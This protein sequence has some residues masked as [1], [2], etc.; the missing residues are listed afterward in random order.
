MGRVRERG[1]RACGSGVWVCGWRGGTTEV[2][3]WQEWVH[4]TNTT[5]HNTTQR[6]AYCPRLSASAILCAE[7][8]RGAADAPWG[9]I[10]VKGSDDPRKRRDGPAEPSDG[11]SA[12]SDVFAH[13][14]GIFRPLL[15]AAHGA[16]LPA[17]WPRVLCWVPNHLRAYPEFPTRIRQCAFRMRRQFFA[18]IRSE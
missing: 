7:Q 13:L 14:T 8:R 15:Q 1:R 6:E 16:A 2:L 5:Q 3:C 9:R 12:S 11:C 17:P 10:R 4:N 18:D